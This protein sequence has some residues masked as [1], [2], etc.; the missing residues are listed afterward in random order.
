M[1]V[2]RTKNLLYEDGWTSLLEHAGFEVERTQRY[3]SPNALRC[4]E[5]GHYFGAPCLLPRL[6]AGRWILAPK[7]WNL[8][9][10]ERLVRRYYDELPSAEGTYTLFLAYKR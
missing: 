9:L 2:S 10:T 5:W 1:W 8:W 6:V 3:F 4:L 7:R